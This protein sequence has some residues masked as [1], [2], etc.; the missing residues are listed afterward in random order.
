V[1]CSGA[2]AGTTHPVHAA[3]ALDAVAPRTESPAARDRSANRAAFDGLDLAIDRPGTQVGEI[4]SDKLLK[5][6]PT[7]TI[8]EAVRMMREHAIRRVP[9]V[10]DSQ[11]VG[12]V[13]IGDLARHQ[14]PK[15]ALAQISAAPPNN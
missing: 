5:L 7:S 15:S 3:R 11:P 2:L 9:V 10:R 6:M 1:Q 14:D 12:I 4:C 8:D 13:T